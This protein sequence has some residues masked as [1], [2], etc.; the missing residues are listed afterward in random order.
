LEGKE[1]PAGE[2]AILTIPAADQWTIILS[3]DAKAGTGDYKQE[4]DAARFNVPAAKLPAVVETFT[5]G[6]ED[7]KGAN[8]TLHFD[9]DMTRAAVKLTTDDVEEVSKKLEAAGA[10]LDPSQ[11]FQAASFYYENNKDMTQAAKW[12]DQALQKNPD[13]WFMHMKKAQIQA[14]LGNKQEAIAAAQKTIELQK[15]SKSPDEGTI[16][17]AQEI[18][19]SAK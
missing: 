2:Y 7:V 4:N 13:V 16:K 1:I 18:I 11:A 14:R 15:A 10:K 12:V 17:S 3:K 6:F 8:A 19:D 5:I 9:W